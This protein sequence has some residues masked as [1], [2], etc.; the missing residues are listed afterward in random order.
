MQKANYNKFPCI[1]IDE[2]IFTVET[3]DYENSTISTTT[4]TLG[5]KH[6]RER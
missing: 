1:K 3:V 4:V 2:C 5:L 6:N